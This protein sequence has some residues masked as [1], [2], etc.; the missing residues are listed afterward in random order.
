MVA[1]INRDFGPIF[2]YTVVP[3]D[4]TNFCGAIA[5]AATLPERTLQPYSPRMPCGGTV[6]A[7]AVTRTVHPPG[8]WERH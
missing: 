6:E 4:L 3:A 5:T 2:R 1:S 7:L 8:V